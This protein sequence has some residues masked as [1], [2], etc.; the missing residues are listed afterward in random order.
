MDA[1]EIV[2]RRLRAQRLAGERFDSPADAVAALGAVQSQEFDQAVWSLAQ[3][4]GHPSATEV[5]EAFDAGDFLR[6]HVL[7]PTW[8]FV[9]PEDIRWMLRLTAPRLAA[10]D[11]SRLRQLHVTEPM[12]ERAAELAQAAL[13]GAGSLT[14]GELR[15][16]FAE[17][18]LELDAGQMG[19]V[20]FH[21]ELRGLICSGPLKGATQTYALL[22]HRTDGG[23]GLEGDEALAELVVRYLT[24]RAPAT[25]ADLAWWSGLTLTDVRR[26]IELSGPL[27]EVDDED[28]RTWY[29]DPDGP[30]A[31]PVRGALML[32]SFEE[33]TVAYKTLRTVSAAGPGTKLP[34]RPVLVD[35]R[36]VG[37]W[38]RT[39]DNTGVAVEVAVFAGSGATDDAALGMEAERYGHHLGREPTLS[40]VTGE[41]VAAA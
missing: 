16:Y 37:T 31:E 12:T 21:L 20:T 24:T 5:R 26:A 2:H 28:G 4:C 1:A 7:R 25:A 10:G 14:R 32:G 6:T 40:I 30:A 22:A 35:G 23:R 17:H 34:L 39:L 41:P 8:H 36:L 19:H 13:A 38:K 9:A 15:A 18:G 3:R 11:R 33:L 27:E 29:L